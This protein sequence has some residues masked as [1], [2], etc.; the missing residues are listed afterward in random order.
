MKRLLIAILIVS[1]VQG[2]F[3]QKIEIKGTIR[4]ATDN[5]ATEFVNVVLQ[6][7]DSV[8]VNG[9]STNNNGSFIFN[10]VEAGNY[11]LVLSCVGYNTQY[12]T[13]NGVKRNTDLGD[14][15]LEDASVA[16]E[17]VIINGSNQINRPDRK[18]VFPSER[19]MKVSTNG[20]NLLQELM[21]PRIQVNPMNNE[22]G[23]SGGGELQIRI[24]GA[25]TD[26][27][28]VKAL[29]PADNPIWKCR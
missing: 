10:K 6:T 7:T 24:N 17:G 8:F 9:V 14:I 1:M 15:L 20:V 3:A 4:N 29:R 26:I 22:I 25:K 23:I 2:V 19:Q 5:E 28:E 21:L 11:R 13:L 27:N 12:I 18:L 16:L